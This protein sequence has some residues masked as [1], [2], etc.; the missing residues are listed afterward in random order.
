MAK[1]I[2][3]TPIL[4]GN[5]AKKF[6]ENMIKEQREPSKIRIETIRKALA[7]YP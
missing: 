7:A 2:A 3:P 6:I 4:W 5:D 1:P